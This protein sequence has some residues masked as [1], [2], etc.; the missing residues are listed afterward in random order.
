MVKTL[1]SQ[2]AYELD[3]RLIDI[4]LDLKDMELDRALTAL[5]YLELTEETRFMW[6]QVMHHFTFFKSS[7]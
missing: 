6:K 4:S 1:V 3:Q 2:V 5:K 7:E